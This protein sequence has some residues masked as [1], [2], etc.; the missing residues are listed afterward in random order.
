[1]AEGERVK[2][3]PQAPGLAAARKIVE[4]LAHLFR[5][6]GVRVAKGGFDAGGFARL[7]RLVG[8][9]D[10]RTAVEMD[11]ADMDALRRHGPADRR[12][13]PARSAKNQRPVP[14]LT[15]HLPLPPDV[16]CRRCARSRRTDGRSM[17]WRGSSG[18]RKRR[19]ACPQMVEVSKAVTWT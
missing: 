14:W 11:A 8:R 10:R 15:C 9:C 3:E 1:R 7:T 17:R 6:G 2:Y 19:R 4:D 13:E 12:A 18:D 5:V 16:R